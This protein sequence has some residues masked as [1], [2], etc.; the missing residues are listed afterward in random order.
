MGS[1][2]IGQIQKMM[3]VHTSRSDIARL[4]VAGSGDDWPI[5]DNGVDEMGLGMKFP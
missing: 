3:P 5:S 2:N 1:E 4:E